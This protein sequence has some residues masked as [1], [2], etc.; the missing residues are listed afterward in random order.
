[1]ANA[2]RGRRGWSCAAG[3]EGGEDA[4]DNGDGDVAAN[5]R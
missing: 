2:R 1:M 4:V 5:A 3:H